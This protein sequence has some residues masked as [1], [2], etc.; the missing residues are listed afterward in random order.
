[1]IRS[2][3]TQ[4]SLCRNQAGALEAFAQNYQHD[5]IET[6]SLMETVQVFKAYQASAEKQ[7]EFLLNDAEV[8][9]LESMLNL[10]VFN[11]DPATTGDT[12]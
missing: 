5:P 11:S 7:L 4:I 12:K 1:M 10:S 8:R 2:L 3:K 9:E 6:A